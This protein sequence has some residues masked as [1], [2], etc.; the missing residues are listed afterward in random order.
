MAGVMKLDRRDFLKLGAVAGG[1]L[2][3]GVYVPE[4]GAALTP[5]AGFQPNAFLRLDA[6]GS[7]TIWLGRSD[8]GQV[9]RTALPMIVADEMDADWARVRVIQ[10]DAHPTDYGRMMTVGSS[11]VRG[12]GWVSR[13]RGGRVGPSSS[14]LA[15]VLPDDARGLGEL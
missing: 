4:R 6:D 11:S 7:L 2:L 15:D 13:R 3:L 1:S 5:A 9:V 8:M 10:A 14:R 12:G